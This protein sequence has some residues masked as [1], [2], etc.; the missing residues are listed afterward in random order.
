MPLNGD[1]VDIEKPDGICLTTFVVDEFTGCYTFKVCIN[2][3]LSDFRH[4]SNSD[5]SVSSEA[6]IVLQKSLFSA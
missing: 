1:S 2:S 5:T 3:T 6:I 4:W